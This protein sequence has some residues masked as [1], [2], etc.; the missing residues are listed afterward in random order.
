MMKC[1]LIVFLASGVVVSAWARSKQP[2][3]EPKPPRQNPAA[4]LPTVDQLLDKYVAALGGKAAIEKI[5][6]RVSKGTFEIPNFSA[7]GSIEIYAKAP[8]KQISISTSPGF[9]VTRR[10]YDGT[11][12]WEQSPMAGL[13]D[14]KG[15]ELA[16]VKRESDLYRSLKFKEFYSTLTVVGKEKV[17]KYDTYVVD[18]IPKEGT[19]EKLYFDRQGGLLVRRDVEMTGRQGKVILNIYTDDYREVDNVKEAFVERRVSSV[20]T[21]NIKL[22]EI[23]HN[24]AVDD[25]KFNKPASQ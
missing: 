17:D 8:N 5:T 22:D 21:L 23:K 7:T 6:S 12:G 14:L 16:S 15:S 9:G 18:A 19:P 10:A 20:F 24:V 13:R 25:A 4:E 3:S 2:A 1:A 11:S